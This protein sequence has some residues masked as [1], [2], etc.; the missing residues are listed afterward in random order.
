M[1]LVLKNLRFHNRNKAILVTQVMFLCLTK[2][3]GFPSRS[4]HYQRKNI[5]VKNVNKPENHEVFFES[6]VCGSL[7]EF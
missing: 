1:K 6:K 7:L 5:T 2:M 3:V 4:H